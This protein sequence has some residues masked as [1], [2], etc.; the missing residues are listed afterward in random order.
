MDK[1]RIETLLQELA[2]QPVGDYRPGLA[3]DIKSQVPPRLHPH[4]GL[5]TINIIID[6][7]IS[8][9]AAAVVIIGTLLFFARFF[10]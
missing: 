4:R 8:R 6:L 3:Q 10:H 2:E 5:D 7:R 9:V 1:Q